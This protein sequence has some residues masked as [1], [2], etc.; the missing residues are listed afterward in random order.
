VSLKYTQRDSLNSASTNIPLLV[1]R[2]LYLLPIPR[3]IS[4]KLTTPT[5]EARA[6]RKPWH[7]A[8]RLSVQVPTNWNALS[9][10]HI[11]S[12]LINNGLVKESTEN[13]TLINW[14]YIQ[15][16]LTTVV[17]DIVFQRTYYRHIHRG[18]MHATNHDHH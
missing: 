10:I 4:F 5:Y 2:E 12:C 8:D 15:T 6:S 16:Q 18:I 7:L 1:R 13:I 17:P 14:T 9:P 11:R 3:R